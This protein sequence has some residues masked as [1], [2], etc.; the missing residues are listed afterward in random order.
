MTAGLVMKM[1]RLAFRLTSGSFV[2]ALAVSPAVGQA[3]WVDPPV[4]TAS[5]PLE[6]VSADDA[7]VPAAPPA[8]AVAPET[9]TPSPTDYEPAI[10]PT[11]APIPPAPAAA[12]S[13]DVPIAGM[14]V[15]PPLP[16]PAVGASV[17][18]YAGR[19]TVSYP[20]RQCHP[21]KKRCRCCLE[22]ELDQ[23][24]IFG[25]APHGAAV[26]ATFGAQIAKADASQMMLYEYDFVP[27]SVELNLRGQYQLAKIAGW[28]VRSP[29]PIVIQSTPGAP[30]L[31]EGR[32]TRI[33]EQLQAG[34]WVGA[35]ERVIIGLP[36]SPGLHGLDA[37]PIAE[38]LPFASV[39]GTPASGSA[40][41]T[42]IP[43]GP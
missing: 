24:C 4:R 19:A 27:T 15:P 3:I 39:G 40:P 28:A 21:P 7:D 34:G 29:F 9:D 16:S 38:R 22:D 11:P 20:C 35:E 26:R 10:S 33:I 1:P 2:V 8:E 43:A 18:P 14:I 41:P 6:L 13:G 32:R 25:I 36:M 30:A 23:R 12:A 31:A 17:T 37:V 5:R 42:P